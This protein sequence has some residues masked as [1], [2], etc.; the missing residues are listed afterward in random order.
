[1]SE[2]DE[3]DNRNLYF[4]AR[5]FPWRIHNTYYLLALLMNGLTLTANNSWCL[6]ESISSLSE[7]VIDYADVS[8]ACRLV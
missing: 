2:T 5:M 8:G 6:Q 7:I 1:M 3:E 4:R